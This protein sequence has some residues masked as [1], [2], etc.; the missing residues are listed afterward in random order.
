MS[1]Q[2]RKQKSFAGT[3]PSRLLLVDDDPALLEALSG[4]LQNRLGHFSLDTC[5][6]G[7]V[8]LN[9]LSERVYDAIIA[10]VNMPG[11]NGLQL[12]GRAKEVR[13]HTLVVLISGHA[14][15]S[16]IAEAFQAGAADFITKPIDRD[17]FVRSMRQVVR[18]SQLRRLLERLEALISRTRERKTR[19][20]RRRTT[21]E[22]FLNKVTQAHQETLALLHAAEAEMRGN[23]V[24]R[25]QRTQ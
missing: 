5:L 21:P 11:M 8:A 15:Q 13:P 10:D 17:M 9:Y 19:A 18:V 4:T 1:E 14:D 7:M 2:A 23:A 6:T 16:L 22:A 20:T 24:L 12:L 3:F 25:L